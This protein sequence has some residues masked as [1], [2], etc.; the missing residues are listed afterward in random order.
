VQ[1]GTE[2]FALPISEPARIDN[3]V[4]GYAMPAGFRHFLG[5]PKPSQ[6]FKAYGIDP[7]G[8]PRHSEKGSRADE[9]FVATDGCGNILARS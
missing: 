4:D 6:R 7:L 1:K 3:S 8:A 9:P 2:A 5:A